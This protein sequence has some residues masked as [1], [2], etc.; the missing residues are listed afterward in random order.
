MN[1]N[2][3]FK[4]KSV[5]KYRGLRTVTV[6]NAFG[7]PTLSK[8]VKEALPKGCLVVLGLQGLLS[9]SKE[10]RLSSRP[11][12]VI[13]VMPLLISSGIPIVGYYELN[14]IWTRSSINIGTYPKTKLEVHGAFMRLPVDLHEAMLR[15]PKKKKWLKS[16]PKGSPEHKLGQSMFSVH[17]PASAL[18]KF[19]ESKKGDVE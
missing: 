11:K 10:D 17:L 19:K 15:A 13:D 7:Y 9:L 1:E 18:D 4:V 12:A 16:L 5:E 8:A 14:G 6:N 3:G 2:S